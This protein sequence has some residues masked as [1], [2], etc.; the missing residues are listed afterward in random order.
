VSSGIEVKCP[1]CGSVEVAG[2]KEKGYECLDCHFKWNP[3]KVKITF[4]SDGTK[5]KSR[6]DK[7]E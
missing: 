2:N 7:S 6:F 3:Y 5:L 1:K 4:E